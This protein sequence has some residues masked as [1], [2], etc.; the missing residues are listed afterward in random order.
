MNIPK[1]IGQGWGKRWSLVDRIFSGVSGELGKMPSFLTNHKAEAEANEI[2]KTKE[3]KPKPL[4]TPLKNA[5][6]RHGVKFAVIA[7]VSMLVT[8]GNL[9]SPSVWLVLPAWLVLGI[10][11]TNQF[12]SVPHD[13]PYKQSCYLMVIP[14]FF[15]AYLWQ[16][17]YLDFFQFLFAPS[18]SHLFRLVSNQTFL[19]LVII[20]FALVTMCYSITVRERDNIIESYK[21]HYAQLD[22]LLKQR[23]ED[24]QK[25]EQAFERCKQRYE[26]IKIE[27]ESHEKMIEILCKHIDEIEQ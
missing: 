12:T 27:K 2:A 5:L 3:G 11:F 9:Q 15:F 16:K 26:E 7:S 8:A 17:P 13:N 1:V 6:R 19:V 23:E 21:Q 24:W 10:V 18:G 20:Y 25:R 14:L 22:K 4:S